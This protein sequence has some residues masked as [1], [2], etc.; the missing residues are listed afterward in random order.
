MKRGKGIKKAGR[1]LGTTTGK[2]IDSANLF[3]LCCIYA[4]IISNKRRKNMKPIAKYC[5]LSK[6]KLMRIENRS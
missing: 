5:Q 2:R 4:I 6:Q 3:Y 1:M